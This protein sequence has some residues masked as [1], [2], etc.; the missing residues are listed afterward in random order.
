VAGEPAQ[1][2]AASARS[3]DKNKLE[4]GEPMIV[5]GYRCLRREF[6]A[7]VARQPPRDGA[8]NA[9]DVHQM[10]IATRRLR[11]ALRLFDHMLPQ[12]TAKDL[13]DNL[14]WFA[15]ALGGVRD[16]DVYSENFRHYLQAVPADRVQELGGYELHLRRARTDARAQLSDLF[17]SERYAEFIA[18]FATFLDGAPSAAALRRWRSFKISDGAEQY[19]RKSRKRVR[20]LGRRIGR[21]ARAKDLHRLRIRAK[22]FRYE[23]EFFLEVYPDLEKA[24]KATKAL[25]DVLGEHQDACTATERLEAYARSLRTHGEAGVPVPAALGHLLEGQEQ[26]ADD[27]RRSFPNEWR[28]FER[29][30]EQT[31]LKLS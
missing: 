25:Q 11:V 18:S 15:G 31:K 1:H 4:P 24:A 16:L 8:P 28:R 9:S 21:D 30:L 17:A 5:L 3:A 20:K 23:L 10:R 26:K 27:A 6:K 2:P 13:K 12:H 14:R 19:L 7:L 22:R 29:V